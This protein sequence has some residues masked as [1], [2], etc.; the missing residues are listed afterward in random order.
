MSQVAEQSLGDCSL[1][2]AIV[3]HFFFDK[4][5]HVHIF[6]HWS[7]YIILNL[8]YDSVE[9]VLAVEGDEVGRQ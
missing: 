7:L 3:V 8:N 6:Q 4:V 1:L 5:C 2:G 9:T